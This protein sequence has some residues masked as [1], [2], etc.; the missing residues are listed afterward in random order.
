MKKGYLDSSS[1][2]ANLKAGAKLDLPYW[3]VKAIHNEKFKFVSITL[4]KPYNKFH[5]EILEADACVVDLRKMGPHYYDFGILLVN[6]FDI[7]QGLNIAR[8]LQWVIEIL[9]SYQIVILF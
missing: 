8:T 2:D 9:A 6:L 7:D 4:P 1:H 5:S 3:L